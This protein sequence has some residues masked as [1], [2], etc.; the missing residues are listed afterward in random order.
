MQ[1]LTG[2]GAAIAVAVLVGSSFVVWSMNGTRADESPTR[3]IGERIDQQ[4]PPVDLQPPDRALAPN[5]DETSF[6]TLQEDGT[7]Y[8]GVTCAENH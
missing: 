4:V 1:P 3:S 8:C 7:T 5:P 2:R 6:G